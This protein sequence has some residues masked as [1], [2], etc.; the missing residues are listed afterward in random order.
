MTDLQELYLKEKTDEVD[1]YE[2]SKNG[3][4]ISPYPLNLPGEMCQV[5]NIREM[6]KRTG[7]DSIINE[8]VIPRK[9]IKQTK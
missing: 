4:K 9:P 7:D 5:T 1:E 6:M 2:K 8:E 3:E